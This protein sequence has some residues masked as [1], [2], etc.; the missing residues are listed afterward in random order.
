MGSSGQIVGML[1]TPPSPAACHTCHQPRAPY[2]IFLL[3]RELMAGYWTLAMDRVAVSHVVLHVTISDLN[4]AP[5]P[6]VPGRML[7]SFRPPIVLF[8]SSEVT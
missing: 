8:Y 7:P 2:N 5:I 1:A 3:F 4:K 6:V